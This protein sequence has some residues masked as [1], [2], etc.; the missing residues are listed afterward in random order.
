MSA[1]VPL[2]IGTVMSHNSEIPA[3]VDNLISCAE[4]DGNGSMSSTLSG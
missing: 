3:S 4:A 1:H 2:M